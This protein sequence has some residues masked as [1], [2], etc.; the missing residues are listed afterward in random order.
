MSYT[1]ED[2]AESLSRVNI[3]RDSVDFVVS[4][5]GSGDGMGTDAG[6]YKWSKDGAT[7]WSGGF[8]L[9]MKDSGF[10]Y[11]T[12]WCD[13]TGWGCQDGAIVLTFDHAPTH[14][15]IRA[16]V[17]AHEDGRYYAAEPPPSEWDIEPSDLNRWLKSSEE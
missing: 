13:Y 5:W 16:A 15:E 1:T 3:K 10:A 6:H 12:G 9:R 14:E 4:A 7:E 11:L 8:L 17:I 2:F